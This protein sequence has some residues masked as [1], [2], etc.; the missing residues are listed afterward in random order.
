MN[1]ERNSGEA[2]LILKRSVSPDGRIDSLSVEVTTPVAEISGPE[3]TMR[4]KHVLGVQAAI[5]TEFLAR[6]PK[7][8]GQRPNG[9]GASRQ[10]GESPAVP[11]VVAGVGGAG[12]CFRKTAPLA[13]TARLSGPR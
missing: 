5:V 9:N 2:Q 8:N 13:A 4:A 7:P 1:G 11:A 10:D 3:I 12:A 6:T